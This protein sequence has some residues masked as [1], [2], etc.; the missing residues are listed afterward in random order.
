MDDGTNAAFRSAFVVLQRGIERA[1]NDRDV[2][3]TTVII[4][5]L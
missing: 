1:C 2:F 5:V 3:Y 4:F